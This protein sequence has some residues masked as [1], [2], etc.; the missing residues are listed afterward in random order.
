MIKP[1][2]NAAETN[3]KYAADGAREAKKQ[4]R[5]QWADTRRIDAGD[6]YF[7]GSGRRETMPWWGYCG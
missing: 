3:R 5:R 1:K 2:C 4:I 7:M 6:N